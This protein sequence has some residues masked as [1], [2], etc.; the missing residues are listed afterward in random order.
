MS[1]YRLLFMK[2][3]EGPVIGSEEI[4]ARDD[5]EA[6]RIASERVGPQ[7]LEL[8]CDKRK[9][10]RFHPVEVRQPTFAF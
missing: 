1:Y 10:K 5:V 4:A 7:P 6:V 3:A 9:I 8:W 2:S